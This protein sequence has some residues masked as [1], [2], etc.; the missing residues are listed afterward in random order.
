VSEFCK[1]FLLALMW[2][3]AVCGAGVY[4]WGVHE[5]GTYDARCIFIGRGYTTWNHVVNHV[6]RID[7]MKVTELIE[8][9]DIY[10]GSPEVGTNKTP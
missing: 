7:C 5:L 9:K 4:F 8:E 6:E 10:G 3:M 2:C 1:W